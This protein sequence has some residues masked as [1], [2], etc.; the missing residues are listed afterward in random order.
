MSKKCLFVE[1][2]HV[3]VN[4]LLF[5]RTLQR[6]SIHEFSLITISQHFSGIPIRENN[7]FIGTKS[8]LSNGFRWCF[9]ATRSLQ[10]L[11]LFLRF[12]FVIGIFELVFEFE[13]LST[14]SPIL[15]DGLWFSVPHFRS[16]YRH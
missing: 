8:L 6:H 4:V 5:F 12:E 13:L 15:F 11:L 14:L 3:H 2:R 9:Y 1:M 7:V 16:K 10:I